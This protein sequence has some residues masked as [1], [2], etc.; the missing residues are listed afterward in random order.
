[1]ARLDEEIKT[2]RSKKVIYIIVGAVAALILLTIILVVAL[3]GKS[4]P[5]KPDKKVVDYIF[6]PYFLSQ[7]QQQTQFSSRYYNLGFD[8]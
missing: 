2:G 5:K 3:K 6:N 8:K 1:M 7:D 4:D